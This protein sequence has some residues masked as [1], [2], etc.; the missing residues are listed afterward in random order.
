MLIQRDDIRET[1][2]DNILDW[3]KAIINYCKDT[4]IKL[5]SLQ[6]EC[7]DFSGDMGQ[8]EFYLIAIMHNPSFCHL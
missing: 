2:E 7:V 1:F 6:M 8:G 4:Q 5:S 3:S